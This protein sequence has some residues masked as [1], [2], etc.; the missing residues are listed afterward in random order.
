MHLIEDEM[1]E[2]Y[3]PDGTLYS[4]KESFVDPIVPTFPF[5]YFL[6]K[7]KNRSMVES[8]NNFD[9]N[10]VAT[11]CWNLQCQ[12]FALK[13]RQI[14]EIEYI[15]HVYGDERGQ[16]FIKSLEKFT[17]TID[18]IKPE[19]DERT[20][21]ITRG[22]HQISNMVIQELKSDGPGVGSVTFECGTVDIKQEIASCKSEADSVINKAEALYFQKVGS[23]CSILNQPL[24]S[25]PITVNI[26]DST[27]I[28]EETLTEIKKIS[29]L[30]DQSRLEALEVLRRKLLHLAEYSNDPEI[31]LGIPK[32]IVNGIVNYTPS[33]N[34]INPQPHIQSIQPQITNTIPN[35]LQNQVPIQQAS[36]QN[37]NAMQYMARY[38]P[39]QYQQQYNPTMG[40][41]NQNQLLGLFRSTPAVPIQVP[42][43]L[44]PVATLNLDQKL[45]DLAQ[46]EN[47]CLN[48][49][50]SIVLNQKIPLCSSNL[51]FKI[52]CIG[53]Y[54][55]RQP[56]NLQ[57]RPQ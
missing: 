25:T 24:I 2:K 44:N 19:I 37:P 17:E 55:Q 36:L 43:S 34:L 45:K 31:D 46:N 32:P 29:N 21:Y 41:P 39:R 56:R 42:T 13:P 26:T 52:A 4:E 27:N 48:C 40:I 6:K 47:K 5:C 51:I 1:F 12:P 30:T 53:Y 7:Y 14:E 11:T 15:S 33:T 9:M 54:Q 50:A 49:K 35:L 28:L 22:A 23:K 8:L 10:A 18:E 20:K 16:H 57:P 38:L 3:N